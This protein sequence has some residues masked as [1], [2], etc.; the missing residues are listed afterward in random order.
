MVKTCLDYFIQFQSIR[1]IKF[2]YNN[3]T[4]RSE[5]RNYYKHNQ[6]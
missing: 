2:A 6:I 1:S 4:S 3:M 5:F